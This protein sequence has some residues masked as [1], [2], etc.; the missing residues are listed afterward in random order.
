M[1]SSKEKTADVII[2]GA[3]MSGLAAADHLRSNGIDD[4]IILEASS[5]LDGQN[6]FPSVCCQGSCFVTCGPGEDRFS[7]LPRILLFLVCV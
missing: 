4:V 1:T 5:R 6:T 2:I 3:G 7:S